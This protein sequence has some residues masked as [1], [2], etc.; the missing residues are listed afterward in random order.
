MKLTPDQIRDISEAVYRSRLGPRDTA[1]MIKDDKDNGERLRSRAAA[2]DSLTR[3]YV[4]II[5]DI[6]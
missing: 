1:S 5:K 3:I 4:T 2:Y 6:P